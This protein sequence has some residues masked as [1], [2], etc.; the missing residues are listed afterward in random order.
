VNEE[1]LG[2]ARRKLSMTVLVHEFFLVVRHIR[3]AALLIYM[4]HPY[5]T[6]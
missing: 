4:S 2:E 6:F 3:D 1:V 5:S